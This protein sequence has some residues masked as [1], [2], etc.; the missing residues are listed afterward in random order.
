MKNDPF[1]M[2]SSL[3]F[4]SGI[5]LILAEAAEQAAR[6]AMRRVRH[7]Y[8]RRVGATLRPGPATPLWNELVQQAQPLLRKR[9]SKAQLGR[10]LQLPRQ[11]V[12]D[13]L[14]AKSAC[15]DAERALLLMCWV[16][17]R[18]QKHPFLL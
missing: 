2:P 12:H 3:E 17:A 4:S 7:H 6:R 9:G 1:A 5:V 13:C 8:R 14:K 15:L 16:A 18:Q 10:L 11:R